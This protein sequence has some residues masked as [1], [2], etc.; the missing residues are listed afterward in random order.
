MTTSTSV[1][2]HPHHEN[3]QHPL[4]VALTKFWRF[5]NFYGEYIS[6]APKDRLNYVE[7]LIQN[8]C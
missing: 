5:S 2:R 8:Q 7:S 1:S 3:R 6:I 4:L